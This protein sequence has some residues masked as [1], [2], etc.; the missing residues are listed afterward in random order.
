MVLNKIPTFQEVKNWATDNN[1]S[2]S[3]LSD[4]VSESDLSF[5]AATQSELD[6]HA[7]NTTNPHNVTDEQ[8]G[9][10]AARSTVAETGDHDDLT[11]VSRSQHG[12]DGNPLPKPDTALYETTST[13]SFSTSPVNPTEGSWM[14]A[15]THT[16]DFSGKALAKFVID[17]RGYVPNGSPA[18][19]PT[20][21]MR[22]L[23]GGKTIIE[24]SIGNL[25]EGAFNSSTETHTID[26]T[27]ETAYDIT[28]EMA[29]SGSNWSS[30]EDLEVTSFDYFAA[31][32]HSDIL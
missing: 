13:D 20:M 30:V 21:E 26:V 23:H 4:L 11:N 1:I 7:G 28:V 17:W 24:S 12:L 10:A 6:S 8:T 16:F 15:G 22:V 25:D 32:S 5:D 29:R 14:E 3:D 9:A 27:D 2:V 31:V 19:F 18:P